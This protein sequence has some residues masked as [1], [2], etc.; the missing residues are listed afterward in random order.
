MGS[1]VVVVVVVVAATVVVVVVATGARLV[2]VVG[3]VVVDVVGSAAG[4]IDP[5][6]HDAATIVR[7]PTR[8]SWVLMS[9]E[10]SRKSGLSA[11][12]K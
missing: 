3:A 6:V 8:R 5:V 7:P 12:L 1:G 9:G 10:R 4:A 11:E 2:V